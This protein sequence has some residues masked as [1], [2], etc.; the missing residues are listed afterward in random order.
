M[1]KLVGNVPIEL[2]QGSTT[3]IRRKFKSTEV[4]LIDKV[5]FSCKELGLCAE[6]EKTEN[7]EFIYTI[8]DELSSTFPPMI[9]TYDLTVQYLDGSVA[10]ETGVVLKVFKRKNP[11]NCEA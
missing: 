10:I 9:T 4:V 8:T 1:A 3:N 5:Y 6:L 2:V 7:N 11:L